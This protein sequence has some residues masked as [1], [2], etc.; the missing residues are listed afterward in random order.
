M[1]IAMAFRPSD[2]SSVVRRR[3][4]IRR[5]RPS[6]I[7]E[8]TALCLM[9]YLATSIE[10]PLQSG[11]DLSVE[12]VDSANA[13]VRQWFSLPNVR[14]IG[15]HTGCSCGFPSILSETPIEY[16]EGMFDDPEQREPDLR[17]LR[18]LIELVRQHV[19]A[20]GSVELYPV[21]HLEE[22]APPQGTIELR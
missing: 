19:E 16:Y 6:R 1:V 8:G 15:A 3:C 5:L 13:D 9:L 4:R 20:T 7:L 10:Q 21:W 11:A 12:E 14:F 2:S 22:S 18:L 17:S